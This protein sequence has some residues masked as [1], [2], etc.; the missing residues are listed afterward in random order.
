MPTG[1]PMAGFAART[2]TSTGV[3]DQLLVLG[4]VV[5]RVALVTVDC[6][7]LHEDSCAEIR[8]LVRDQVEDAVVTATHTHSGPC[9]APGRLGPAAPEVLAAVIRAAADVIGRAAASARDCTVSHA[10]V[11]GL[12]VAADRRH[13]DRAI[14]PPLQAVRFTD[15]GGSVIAHLVSYP[16]HP[17]VLDAGNTLIS[18]DYP[19]RLRTA[20]E[21]DH[22]GSICLFATGC[23][24]DINTGHSAEASYTTQRTSTR[25]FEEADRIGTR[26]ASAL[27]TAIFEPI[28]IAGLGSGPPTSSGR[29][30][31]ASGPSTSSGPRGA[32]RLRTCAV[33][34]PFGAVDRTA[35]AA[36]A[37]GWREEIGTADAGRAALLRSWIGWAERRTDS[38]PAGWHG[39][40]GLIEIGELAVV[41]LPGEPFWAVAEAIRDLRDGPTLVLGY[42]DGVP[43][44]FPT[45]EDY[46]D[47]GYEV[48]DAHRYYG[49]PAPFA[50]G[51]AEQLVDSAGLLIN[52]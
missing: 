33:E 37:D 14:D 40:V 17:V 28:M 22:P 38:D 35:V 49:M 44:Y 39:R 42:S 48:R 2:G 29:W 8:D 36:E 31:S 7:A 45:K 27:R 41:C 47:G 9:I 46:P 6:C 50:A 30:G 16:C 15:S 13:L 21:A 18:A 5:D 10:E 51:C 19:H 43:G 3:H 24:G 4:L 26:L 32:V 34:L 52:G 12:G 23:A 1:T 20:V 11:R 25:T